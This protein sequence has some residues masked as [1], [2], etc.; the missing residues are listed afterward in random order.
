[1]GPDQLLA[2]I[3]RV[4]VEVIAPSL[5]DLFCKSL[6][7]GTLPEDWKL[8]NVVPAYKKDQ[9][10]QVENYRPISLLPIVS[11]ALERCIFNN[12]KDHVLSLIAKCQ[13]GFIAGRSCVTQL[14]G[15]LDQSGAYINNGGQ[16]D[17][18]YL[19]MS[20]AFDKVSHRKLLQKVRQYGFGGNLLSWFKSY[21]CNRTQR[22]IA[23]GAT[24]KTLPV[25]SRV[26]QSAP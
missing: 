21:L 2:R 9:K 6:R 18:I 13:H 15:V 16:V 23:V 25:T 4:T 22:V 5:T 12:I 7:L 10:D 19:D 20:K 14:V 3:L 24:S 1:M 8:A 17:I 11:K 26:P